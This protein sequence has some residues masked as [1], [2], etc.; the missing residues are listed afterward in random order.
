MNIF[1]GLV[2]PKKGDEK[3]MWRNYAPKNSSF[4]SKIL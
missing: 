3:N 2:T 1:I 4:F